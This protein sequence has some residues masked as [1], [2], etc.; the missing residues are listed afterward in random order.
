MRRA[1]MVLL[2][3]ITLNTLIYGDEKGFNSS[4]IVEIKVY[5]NLANVEVLSYEGQLEFLSKSAREILPLNKCDIS[6]QIS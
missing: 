5:Y 4:K 3:I 6:S 2:I 1:F